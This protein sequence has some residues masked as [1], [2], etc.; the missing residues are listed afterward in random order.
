MPIVTMRS[1]LT[2]SDIRTLIRGPTEE[3]RAHAAHKICR[4]IEDGELA[5]EDELGPEWRP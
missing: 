3:D 5:P 1:Q 4:C 2:D